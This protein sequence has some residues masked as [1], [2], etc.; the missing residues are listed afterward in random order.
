MSKTLYFNEKL[1]HELT[2]EY[3]AT[4][5]IDEETYSNVTEYLEYARENE[6][7][8]DELHEYAF[9]SDNKNLAVYVTRPHPSEFSQYCLHVM[10]GLEEH[11]MDENG[12][13]AQYLYGVFDLDKKPF[14]SE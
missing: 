14:L 1:S 6:C 7:W 8:D 3:P 2:N 5:I 4:F 12:E 9:N 11:P 13:P 10:Y